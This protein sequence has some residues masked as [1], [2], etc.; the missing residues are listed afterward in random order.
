MKVKHALPSFTSQLNPLSRA[1]PGP[2][3]SQGEIKRGSEGEGEQSPSFRACPR[4]SGAL[5]RHSRAFRRC[6]L[7]VIPAEAGT[8]RKAKHTAPILHTLVQ[9]PVSH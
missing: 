8:Q 3:P 7:T 9:T 4:H 5:A 1:G 6:P 2:S